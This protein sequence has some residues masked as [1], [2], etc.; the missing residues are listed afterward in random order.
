MLP[1]YLYLIQLTSISYFL[2]ET[3]DVNPCMRVKSYFNKNKTT[4]T[5]LLIVG[6]ALKTRTQALQPQR[7]DWLWKPV[8]MPAERLTS[9]QLISAIFSP[10]LHSCGFQPFDGDTLC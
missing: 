7:G 6:H 10:V 3:S 8:V 5:C 4:T 1:V 2:P 9:L